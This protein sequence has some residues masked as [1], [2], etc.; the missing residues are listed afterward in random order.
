MSGGQIGYMHII[1]NRRAIGR[2]K[3]SAEYRDVIR[4]TGRSVQNVRDQMCFRIVMF[5]L[6]SV[7]TSRV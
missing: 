1:A 6:I 5:A 2:G 7:S 4:Q 3:I